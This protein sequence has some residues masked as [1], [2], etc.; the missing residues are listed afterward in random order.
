MPVFGPKS[1]KQVPRNLFTWV[2]VGTVC[3]FCLFCGHCVGVYSPLVI[4]I[5][6]FLYDFYITSLARFPT[7]SPSPVATSQ[8]ECGVAGQSLTFS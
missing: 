1:A 6:I 4:N 5:Y 3:A 8:K 2:T 7:S